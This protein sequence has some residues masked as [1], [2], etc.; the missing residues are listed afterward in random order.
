MLKSK[1]WYRHK[2]KPIT[3]AKEGKIS[4]NFAILTDRKIKKQ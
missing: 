2:L 3:E 4:G 1:K